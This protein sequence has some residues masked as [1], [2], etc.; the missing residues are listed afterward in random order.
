MFLPREVVGR[1]GRLR[2]RLEEVM[3]TAAWV[4]SDMVGIGIGL[5]AVFM[6]IKGRERE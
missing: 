1:G 3:V 6:I 5:E 4:N 2:E